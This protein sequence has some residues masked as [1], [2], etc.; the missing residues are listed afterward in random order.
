M[1]SSLLSSL[2]ER[3]RSARRERG[4]SQR[5]L[6]ANAGISPR[7]LVQLEAG[8]ANVSLQK[9]AGLAAAFDCSLV[10][11][12]AGAGPVR[13][14]VDR[15]ASA[16]RD[17]SPQELDHLVLALEGARKEKVALVGL[18]GAGKTTVGRAVARVAGCSFVELNR[19]VE[20]QAGMSLG[21]IF[22]YHGV[23]RYRALSQESL[24]AVLAEPGPC[25]LEVGGSLVLDQVAYDMLRDHTRVVWLAASP[26]EHLRRVAAQGDTRPMAGRED[27]LGELQAILERREALY[28]L[29]DQRVDTEIE[30]VAGSVAVVAGLLV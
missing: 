25:V 20:E 30:G 10:T 28:A 17:Q 27:A 14:A 2:G 7:F 3:V 19:R 22:E 16:A 13:D 9:L 8:E 18:R 5:A 6:A 12:L 23:E 4:W 26:E 15:I 21:E 29:A 24:E 11:L 1:D